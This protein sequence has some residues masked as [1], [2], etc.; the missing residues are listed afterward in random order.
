MHSSIKI[1]LPTD[2]LL[3]QSRLSNICVDNKMFLL[4]RKQELCIN[5]QMLLLLGPT[6]FIEVSKT[7]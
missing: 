3:P 7:K 1:Y 4:Q 6:E 2:T 5:E